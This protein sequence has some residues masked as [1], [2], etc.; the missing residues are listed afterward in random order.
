MKRPRS[1]APSRRLLAVGCALCALAVASFVIIGSRSKHSTSD[2]AGGASP[3]PAAVST[4]PPR[5][6]GG[7][8]VTRQLGA[9][10]PNAKASELAK[11]VPS[12]Q[13]ATLS[14]DATVPSGPLLRTPEGRIDPSGLTSFTPVR[15]PGDE[16]A[17]DGEKVTAYVASPSSGKRLALTVNQLGEFPRIWANP[18]ERVEVRLAFTSTQPG[19]R[20]AI[21]AQDGGKLAGT[22]LSAALPVDDARQIAFAFTVS[23]NVGLH[24]VSIT[25]PTGE[26]KTLEFWA[27]P[28][29]VLMRSAGL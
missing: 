17:Y 5:K 12:L 3:P 8:G 11:T 18:S 19:G 15:F 7:A 4:T 16:P 24:R 13:P 14:A 27:G 6:G 25:S 9:T 20:V 10:P 1:T 28:P 29:P 2:A 26:A 22:K 23:P 21:V